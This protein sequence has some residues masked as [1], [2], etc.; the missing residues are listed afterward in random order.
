MTQFVTPD[1]N[2]TTTTNGA[3]AFSS[4]NNGNLDFFN[5]SGNV[6]YP[7][8]FKDF[9]KALEEDVDIALRNLL[10]TRDIRGGKGIRDNSRKLLIH[11]ANLHPQL[12]LKTN[13]ITRFI[14]LGRWDDIFVLATTP[15]YTITQLVVK[16]V[17]L[18]L[19]KP[20]V[21]NLLLKWLPIN[22]KRENDKK[23]L[24]LV[25]NY[26]K[27]TA[28]DLRKYVTSR[29]K[30]FIPE[31]KFCEKQ[32]NLL[33]YSAIPSQCFRK[34]KQSFKRNDGERFDSFINQALNG[35]VVNGKQVS[36]KAGAIWPHEVI[37]HLSSL[38]MYGYQ[39]NGAT[40]P[41]D[42]SVEAQWNALPDFIPEGV[43]ILPVID[44]SSSMFTKA[45]SNFTCL[46]LSII[47][48]LYCSEKN[49]S[50]YKDCFLTFNSTPQF[51]NL[52]DTPSLSL[53]LNMISKAPWG[54]T[55]NL[56]ATFDLILAKAVEAKVPQ[57]LMPSH[58]LIITDGQFNAMCRG[59]LP[60][61]AIKLKYLAAGYEV[62]KVIFWNVRDVQ[63]VEVTM[64]ELNVA[65][66]SGYSPSVLKTVFNAD[67][68]R[69]SP[70][71]IMLDVL[72]EPK[73]R[74]EYE[75]KV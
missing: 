13:L 17:S 20:N 57:E 45:Y 10:N 25:R 38:N 55:T 63:N 4:T 3:L 44:T 15:N 7:N 59:G 23:F 33:D 62:P 65:L 60:I 11:L 28:K 72:N 61:D 46:D 48:G 54:G 18:E 68:E 35:E 47:L 24:Y 14:E 19:L 64:N 51:I 41:I 56:E 21:D 42:S 66:I 53:R 36:V 74:I 52:T 5:K 9:D 8:L 34:N 29:R 2:L 67:F 40:I 12:I 1:S 22:S 39:N 71:N 75:E 37:G 30:V 70:I 32:W 58:V 27:M 6:S 16:T 31:F 43:N 26:V 49:K 69:Y 73:Y 50:I